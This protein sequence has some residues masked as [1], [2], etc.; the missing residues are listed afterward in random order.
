M[1]RWCDDL[2]ATRKM[3]RVILK[4]LRL[5]TGSAIDDW[6][7]GG[8]KIKLCMSYWTENIRRVLPWRW[9]VVNGRGFSCYTEK[10]KSEKRELHQINVQP[11]NEK[12]HDNGSGPRHSR[13]ANG[14]MDMDRCGGLVRLLTSV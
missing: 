11:V 2:P 13:A 1:M 4:A 5:R 8:E 6:V 7:L 9:R 12:G 14:D 10:F 3:L